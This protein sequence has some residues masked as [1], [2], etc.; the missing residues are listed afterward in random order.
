MIK[1]ENDV[2]INDLKSQLITLKSAFE[3]YPHIFSLDEEY[4]QK[5]FDSDIN[6]ELAS[7]LWMLILSAKDMNKDKNNDIIF[8]EWE[9]AINKF[10]N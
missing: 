2:K 5:L 3:I 10:I 8:W 6:K 7:L 1:K 9:D 4:M